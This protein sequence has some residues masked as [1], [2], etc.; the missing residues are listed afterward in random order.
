MHNFIGINMYNYTL[1]EL[2]VIIIHEHVAM[3]KYPIRWC[4]KTSAPINV[5]HCK[6]AHAA[7]PSLNSHIIMCMCTKQRRIKVQN[8]Y[9]TLF[10]VSWC[11]QQ[12]FV[13]LW[14]EA[15]VHYHHHHQRG[16]ER[17]HQHASSGRRHCLPLTEGVCP[18]V[19]LYVCLSVCQSVT[20]LDASAPIYTFNQQVS[21][22]ILTC[23]FLI[24]L[25]V[26]KLWHE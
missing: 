14:K 18:S 3:R 10:Y 4:I 21:L 19:C 24:T 9:L 13:S 6:W 7:A 12:K 16:G 17:D 25:S 26:Q 20:T 2:W 23:G 5:V 15:A 1:I 11:G 8:Q 22:R